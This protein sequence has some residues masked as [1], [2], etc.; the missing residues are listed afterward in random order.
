VAEIVRARTYESAEE[1]IR[2]AQQCKVEKARLPNEQQDLPAPMRPRSAT[3]ESTSDGLSD[4]RPSCSSTSGRRN[5]R[6]TILPAPS[7]EPEEAEDE[8]EDEPKGVGS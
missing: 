2:V 4:L 1:G 6:L 8:R 3:S 7:K 5:R